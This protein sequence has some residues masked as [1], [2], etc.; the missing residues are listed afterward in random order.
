MSVLQWVGLDSASDNGRTVFSEV[1]IY[2][3][4][5][6]SWLSLSQRYTLLAKNSAQWCHTQS[7]R[8]RI[9]PDIDNIDTSVGIGIG[10]VLTCWP[11]FIKK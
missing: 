4:K 8:G 9:D 10:S 6:Q 3:K 2:V 5:K 11:R 1:M 7:R